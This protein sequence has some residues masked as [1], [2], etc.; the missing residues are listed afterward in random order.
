MKI[1]K[2]SSIPNNE[3]LAKLDLIAQLQTGLSATQ[4]LIDYTLEINA[5]DALSMSQ[6]IARR[7]NE[8]ADLKIKIA[9]LNAEIATQHSWES[10]CKK[11]R[12]DLTS[13]LQV[14]QKYEAQLKRAAG[15][16]DLIINGLIFEPP[17]T[18]SHASVND[19]LDDKGTWKV[20][21]ILESDQAIGLQTL[22]DKAREAE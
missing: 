1:K 19:A 21:K 8:I 14:S 22:F 11:A 5:Q 10:A 13:A 3:Y 9:N 12:R 18:A 2:R 7:D 15:L 4:K 6:S 17:S 16:I 20:D